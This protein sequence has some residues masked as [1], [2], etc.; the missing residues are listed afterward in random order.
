MRRIPV[1]RSPG[2]TGGRRPRRAF[3]LLVLP[4]VALAAAMLSCEESATDEDSSDLSRIEIVSGNSQS[5]RVGALLPEPLVVRVTD[6]LGDPRKNIEVR[7][8]IDAAGGS[9]TPMVTTTDDGGTAS[10]VCR[11]GSTPGTQHVGAAA[12]GDSTVFTFSAQALACGEEDPAAACAWPE[13]HVFITTTSS[14]LISATGSV[15]IDFD[16][17]AGEIEKV[18]ETSEILVDLAFS[19]RGELFVATNSAIYKVDP[20]SKTLAL[21]ATMMPTSGL[22]IDGNP[23]GILGAMLDLGFAYVGCPPDLGW[24]FPLID[25]DY[26]A[27]TIRP[28]TR[29]VVVPGGSG[30]SRNVRS[31]AWDGRSDWAQEIGSLILYVGTGAPRGACSDDEGTVYITIDGNDA[32]RR[33]AR[34]TAAGTVE[35][36]WFDFY[37]YF[38]GNSTAAG[39]WGDIALLGDR[40]FLIDRRN[41]RLV[42]ITTAGEWDA[43][44]ESD[45]FSLP[46]QENERYGIAAPPRRDCP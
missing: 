16:P 22:E 3:A 41:D 1:R 32:H 12:G 36:A 15:L 19:S 2:S 23:G 18:L 24:V 21:F 46:G 39:R 10:T 11:L 45:Y 30:T 13:D 9:V 20:V 34:I 17:G 26:E 35:P 8:D 27:M 5:E 44:W 7:F 4:A 40:L 31:W 42:A 6:I 29:T 28:D 38:G 25:S 43:S 37:A 33:I 14:A